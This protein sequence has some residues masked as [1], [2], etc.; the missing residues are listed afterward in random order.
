M[1]SKSEESR[2]RRAELHLEDLKELCENWREMAEELEKENNA[3][4]RELESVKRETGESS[5]EFERLTQELREVQ[6]EVARFGRE[7]VGFYMKS[8]DSPV[9]LN[10]TSSS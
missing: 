10:R 9:V 2:I 1:S 6:E 8:L 5:R 3:A 7:E 4:A